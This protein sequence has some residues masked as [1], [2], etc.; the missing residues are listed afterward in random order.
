MT[1]AQE[2]CLDA[3][4]FIAALSPQEH[5]HKEAL[6]LIQDIRVQ[7]KTLYEPPLALYEVN[8]ALYRKQHLGEMSA[9]DTQALSEKF[10]QLPILFQWTAEL[11][12]FTHQLGRQLS[13]AHIYDVSYLALAMTR[14]IPLVTFDDELLRKGKK[15][16]RLLFSAKDAYRLTSPSS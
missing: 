15:A 16:H 4:I 5:H 13:F 3:N 14:N 12:Q 2:L 8:M 9:Q 1:D 6:L 11:I 10:S 7:S